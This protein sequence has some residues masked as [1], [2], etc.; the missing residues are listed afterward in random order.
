MFLG[1]RNRRIQVT[2]WDLGYQALLDMDEAEIVSVI[3]YRV[4][5]DRPLMAIEWSSRR[6]QWIYAPG[7]V[8]R[9]LYWDQ[10]RVQTIDRGEAERISRELLGTTL[11]SEEQTMAMFEEGERMG[12]TY[13]P[14]YQGNG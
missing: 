8:S 14:P 10:D 4:E 6:S 13:G 12:W 11:P 2:D 3:V 7:L 9:F 1:L 5:E